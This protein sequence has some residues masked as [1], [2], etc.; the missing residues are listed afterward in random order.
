MITDVTSALHQHRR[1][2]DFILFEGAQEFI[3]TWIKGLTLLLLP[4]IRVSEVSPMVQV[5]S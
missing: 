5:W 4:Q 3:L 1:Q 2:S